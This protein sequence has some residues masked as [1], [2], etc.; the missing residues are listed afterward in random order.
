MEDVVARQIQGADIDP[1][2]AT[3]AK[4][5]LYIAIQH[6]RDAEPSTVDPL[7]NLETRILCADSLSTPLKP[8]TL[9]RDPEWQDALERRRRAEAQWVEADSPAEKEHAGKALKAT[10]LALLK[11][12]PGMLANGREHRWDGHPAHQTTPFRGDLPALAGMPDGWDLVIGNPPYMNVS[13][14]QRRT[15]ER[16]GYAA[17]PGNLYGAF[18]ESAAERLVKRNGSLMMI[19]PHSIQWSVRTKTLRGIIENQFPE[20]RVRTYDNRTVAVFPKTS[21]LEH[22]TNPENGQRVCVI[23]AESRGDRLT[24]RVRSTGLIRLTAPTRADALKRLTPTGEPGPSPA[25]TDG[26]WPATGSTELKQLLGTMT[27]GPATERHAHALTRPSS[28]LT[29]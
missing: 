26:A 15:F 29:S 4:L 21:W 13:A 8:P 3:I 2:A 19:V 18:L 28:G 12:Y 27:R 14:V 7:P 25:G 11:V 5:R 24:R 1:G 9:I 6:E 10:N 17:G 23:H 16:L 22:T 20:I